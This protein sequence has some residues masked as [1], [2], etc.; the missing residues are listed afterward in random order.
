MNSDEK[1]DTARSHLDCVNFLLLCNK[2]PQTS[3]LK[4]PH[5]WGHGSVGQK[6]GRVQ[7]GPLLWGSQAWNKGVNQVAFSPLEAQIGKNPLLDSF[8]LLADFTSSW[9]QNKV[10]K[11]WL[12]VSWLLSTTRGCLCAY[13]PGFF[14]SS[15]SL[16]KNPENPPFALHC[17]IIKGVISH[18]IWRFYPHLTGRHLC[19]G[20]GH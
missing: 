6:L 17:N 16:K 13:S 18:P 10:P 14:L 8:R 2:W 15:H 19:R 11:S 7:L 20:K 9:S 5:L 12:T 1:S 4:Q 3:G